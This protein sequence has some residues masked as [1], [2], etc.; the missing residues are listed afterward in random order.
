MSRHHARVTANPF[1]AARDYRLALWLSIGLLAGCG[2]EPPADSAVEA[3][4]ATPLLLT[5]ETQGELRAAQVTQLAVP[6]EG[7]TSRQLVWMVP[8]GSRVAKNDV[9]ARFSAARVQLEFDKALHE[10][11]RNRLARLAKE[12]ELALGEHRLA[13][14][15]AR[16]ESE[17]AIAA[18]YAQAEIT[19]IAR[20]MIL[21]AITDERFLREKQAV[22]DW[23]EDQSAVRGDAERRVLEARQQ[24]VATQLRTLAADLGALELRA[25]HDGIFLLSADWS[26]EK[27]RLGAQFFAGN[28]FATL[29]DQRALEVELRVP[30]LEAEGI[31]VGLPVRLHPIGEPAQGFEAPITWV[32]HAPRAVSRHEPMRYLV[33]RVAVPEAVA[34]RDAWVPG[35]TFVGQVILKSSARALSVPNLALLSAGDSHTVYVLTPEGPQQ[36]RVV[37]GARG[38]ARSEVLEGLAEGERVLL[39]PTAR[40]AE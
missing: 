33:F 36:R 3:V 14:D 23:R 25:P 37:L 13:V 5:I 6:G 21:D 17:L 8:D 9:V 10:L 30:Q 7:F 11:E 20:N 1:R 4:R 15:R 34:R 19:A 28:D 24:A 26:G 35:Q 31:A 2:R 38:P 12:A 29:P 27:P 32:A 16:V 22:L 40:D 18:R 39:L